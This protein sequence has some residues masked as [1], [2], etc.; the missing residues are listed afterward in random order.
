MSGAILSLYTLAK[1]YHTRLHAEIDI[2]IQLSS[3]MPDIEEILKP[4]SLSNI[5]ME[6]IAIFP[7]ECELCEYVTYSPL[8]FKLTSIFITSLFSNKVINRHNP[9]EQKLL[10]K[11]LKIC[12]H[13]KSD[14]EIEKKF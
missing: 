4:M 2:R 10:H 9:H 1:T 8:F 7:S 11:V 14:P 12:K 3:I 13:V 5:T 6:N